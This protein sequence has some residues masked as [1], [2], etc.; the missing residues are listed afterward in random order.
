MIWGMGS[1]KNYGVQ[2]EG[3]G[4]SVYI[5]KAPKKYHHLHPHIETKTE[6]FLLL[7]HHHMSILYEEKIK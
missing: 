4:P 3:V 6:L 2:P 1:N 7:G 5:P